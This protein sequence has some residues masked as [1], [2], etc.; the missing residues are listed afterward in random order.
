MSLLNR[1]RTNMK[2]IVMTKNFRISIP[3]EVCESQGWIPGQKLEFVARGGGYELVPVL[4]P[5]NLVG[6]AEV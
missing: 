5:E 2:P 1:N 4:K 6:T 3:K